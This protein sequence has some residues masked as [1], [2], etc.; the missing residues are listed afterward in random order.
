MSSSRCQVL[1]I[2]MIMHL[3]QLTVIQI[4]N[5]SKLLVLKLLSFF[6]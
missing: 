5:L 1:K 3:S 4:L 2:S 6:Y